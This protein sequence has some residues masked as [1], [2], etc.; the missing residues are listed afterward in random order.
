MKKKKSVEHTFLDE[1]ND[2]QNAGKELTFQEINTIGQRVER[3]SEEIADKINSIVRLSDVDELGKSLTE[4]LAAAK[5]YDPETFNPRGIWRFLSLIR[6]VDPREQ[7]DSVDAQVKVLIETVEQK[8]STFR[9]RIDDIEG[10]YG[11]IENHQR[12]SDSNTVNVV[13]GLVG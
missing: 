6:S 11:E 12:P 9:E 8:A 4:L 3:A 1:S 2:R 5:K 13:N 7:Y 10:I